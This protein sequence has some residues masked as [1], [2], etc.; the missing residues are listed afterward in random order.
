[1]KKLYEDINQLEPFL[2]TQRVNSFKNYIKTKTS[3]TAQTQV[4]DISLDLYKWNIKISGAFLELLQL[5]E[6]CL[7]NAIMKLISHKYKYYIFDNAFRKKL[8]KYAHNELITKINKYLNDNQIKDSNNNIIV[9]NVTSKNINSTQIDLGIIISKL[10]LSFWSSVLSSNFNGDW[11]YHA[12]KA[13]PMIKN[14]SYNTE[15][16]HI[17]NKADKI[18]NLRNKICHST[19]IYKDDLKGIFKDIFYILIRIDK[20]LAKFAYKNQRITKILKECPI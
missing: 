5:Y 19:H 15:I 16:I 8:N 20:N 3:I 13:F 18:K 17:Y 1:M 11:D 7:R 12:K 9:Y 14:S 6:V 4:D 10:Y 2:S